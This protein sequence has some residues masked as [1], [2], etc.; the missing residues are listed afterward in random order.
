M[1]DKLNLGIDSSIVLLSKEQ[2][3]EKYIM[4]YMKNTLKLKTLILMK[5]Y[6]QTDIVI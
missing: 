6:Y 3:K 5:N 4:N 1:K 2:K